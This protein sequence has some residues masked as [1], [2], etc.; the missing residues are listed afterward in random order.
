MCKQSVQKGQIRSHAD[1]KAVNEHTGR[2]LKSK[3]FNTM[4]RETKRGWGFIASDPGEKE[5]V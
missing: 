4:H 5:A 3:D 2:A 1:A